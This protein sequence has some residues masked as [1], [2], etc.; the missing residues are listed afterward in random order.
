M[1]KDI[2]LLSKFSLSKQNHQYIIQYYY[3]TVVRRR[4]YLYLDTVQFYFHYRFNDV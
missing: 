3:D 2:M 1:P 4:H